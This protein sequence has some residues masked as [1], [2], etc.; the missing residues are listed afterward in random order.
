VTDLN[1]FEPGTTIKFRHGLGMA[2]VVLNSSDHIAD[3]LVIDELDRVP[4][5]GV[6]TEYHDEIEASEPPDDVVTIFNLYFEDGTEPATLRVPVFVGQ[7]DYDG[8]DLRMVHYENGSWNDLNAT[9]VDDAY[10]DGYHMVTLEGHA[11]S[12]S[13]FAVVADE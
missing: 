10:F 2:E 11:N 13:L 5:Q 9:V 8:D 6:R 1:A 4:P 7:E 3:E 12:T